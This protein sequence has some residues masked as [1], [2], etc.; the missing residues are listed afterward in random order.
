MET[1]S[2]ESALEDHSEMEDKQTRQIALQAPP[3][4]LQLLQ[5]LF[6]S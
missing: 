4:V 3:Q 5:G 1:L 2:L 6:D